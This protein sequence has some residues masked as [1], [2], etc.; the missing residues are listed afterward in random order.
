[1]NKEMMND[2][3]RGEICYFCK[4]DLKN[5]DRREKTELRCCKLVAHKKELFQWFLKHQYCPNCLAD[6]KKVRQQILDWGLKKNS[7]KKKKKKSIEH[8]KWKDQRYEKRLRDTKK[9]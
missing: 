5:T 8:R 4:V 6:D 1:M 9:N 2:V 3:G 7:K